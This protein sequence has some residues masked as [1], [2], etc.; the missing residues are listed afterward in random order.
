MRQHLQEVMIRHWRCGEGGV[1][2]WV[3]LMTPLT[4]LGDQQ[5]D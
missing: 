1:L 4:K 3:T 5:E 2:V